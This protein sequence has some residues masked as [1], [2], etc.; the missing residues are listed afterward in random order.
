MPAPAPYDYVELT[1]PAGDWPVGTRGH[2]IEVYPGGGGLVEVE[3][4]AEGHD[5][6]VNYLA[7][8]ELS[9]LRVLAPAPARP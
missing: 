7:P 8:V 3:G 6:A 5:P 9:A 2:L 1:A 4:A